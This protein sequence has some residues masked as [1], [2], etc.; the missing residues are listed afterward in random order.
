MKNPVVVTNYRELRALFKAFA[1]GHLPFVV[2]LATPG[3][4]KSHNIEKMLK[5]KGCLFLGGGSM[6]AFGTYCEIV[7]HKRV[8]LF[9]F[10]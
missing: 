5:K 9:P 4:G 3:L 1:N 2:L 8:R 7:A 6:S 10:T